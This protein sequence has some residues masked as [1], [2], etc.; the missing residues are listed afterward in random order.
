[1]PKHV[2]RNIFIWYDAQVN[3]GIYSDITICILKCVQMCRYICIYINIYIYIDTC[4]GK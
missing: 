4:T 2:L 1:M 3:L